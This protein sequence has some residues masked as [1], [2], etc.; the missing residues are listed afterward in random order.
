MFFDTLTQVTSTENT[1]FFLVWGKSHKVIAFSPQTAYSKCTICYFQAQINLLTAKTDAYRF[2]CFTIKI[3][4]LSKCRETTKNPDDV[5]L[6]IAKKDI[7][8]ELKSI[9]YSKQ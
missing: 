3:S 9:V 6:Y 5:I 4:G 2:I 7:S 8:G 1:I